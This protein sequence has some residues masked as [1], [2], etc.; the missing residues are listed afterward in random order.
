[1]TS[2]LPQGTALS[3]I[4]GPDSGEDGQFMLIAGRRGVESIVVSQLAGPVGWYDVAVAHWDDGRPDQIYPLYVLV[5]I[6]C[7]EAT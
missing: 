5:F 1:M 4:S 2:E 3:A 6:Q 7:A